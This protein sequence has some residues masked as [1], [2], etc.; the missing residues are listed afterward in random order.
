M[1]KP[2]EAVLII[3][4]VHGMIMAGWIA[5]IPYVKDKLEMSEGTL[6]LVLLAASLGIIMSLPIVGGFIN[7]YS[8]RR[9]T[10]WGS[11][12]YATFLPFLML[13][14]SVPTL[15][16]ML[17]IYASGAAF[18][19]ISMN[20]QAVEV[21]KQA[22]KPLMSSFHGAFSIGNF[23]GAILSSAIIYLDIDPVWHLVIFTVL[24]WILVNA[25]TPALIPDTQ[26]EGD[27]GEK[28]SPI[29]TLPPKVILPLGIIAFCAAIGEGAMN[30]WTTVYLK[31]VLK[32]SEGFATFGFAAFSLMMTVGRFSG[33]Y[34][35]QR[36]GRVIMIQGGALVTSLG[37]ILVVL[38]PSAYVSLIGFAL[39]GAGL[40]L[41]IPIVF[42]VAG[43][44]PDIPAGTGIASAASLGYLGFLAGPP[45]IGFLAELSSLRLSFLF[46]AILMAV[47]LAIVPYA[48]PKHIVKPVFE[49]A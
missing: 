25:V 5:R 29:F 9:V 2:R 38:I 34:L 48:I 42:S 47:L 6:G 44:M 45:I 26:P 46:V 37:L 7:R 33:D 8:S 13:M 12:A 31:D 20:A 22:K 41:M 3:F 23:I 17:F 14:P 32:T 15:A 27:G 40:A 35:I 39:A 24:A 16:I 19:D 10:W 1:I 43:T 4:A 49:K 21:E 30:D 28:P 36:F 11:M 18:M